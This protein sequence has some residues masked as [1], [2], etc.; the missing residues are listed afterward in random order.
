MF[1]YMNKRSTNTHPR[2]QGWHPADI[3]AGLRKR[4]WSLSRLSIHHGYKTR[5]ALSNALRHPWPKGERLIAEVLGVHPQ[6]VW[7]DRYGADGLP[8]RPHGR[9]RKSSVRNIRICPLCNTETVGQK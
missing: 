1:S 3:V 4:G 5:Q 7:P 8:N 2:P 9:P 6:E